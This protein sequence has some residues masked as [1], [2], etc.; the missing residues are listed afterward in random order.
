MGL[1]NIIDE[2]VL[3][4]QSVDGISGGAAKVYGYWNHVESEAEVKEKYVANGI[5]HAW[6]VTR[7]STAAEDLG[8]NYRRDRHKITIVGFRSAQKHADGEQR[9]QETAEGVRAVFDPQGAR[10][11]PNQAG[12][13][14]TPVQVEEVGAAVFAGFGLCWYAKLSFLVEQERI[15]S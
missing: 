7:E 13:I 6:V 11:L 14:R 12:F 4:V 8:P 15:G 5:I 3:L 9:L 1:T 10:H 2:I